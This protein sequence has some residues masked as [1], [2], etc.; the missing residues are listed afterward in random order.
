MKRTSLGIVA[1][2]C[3]F[4]GHTSAQS[5]DI[6]MSYYDTE[7][8]MLSCTKLGALTVSYQN[9]LY[10]TQFLLSRDLRNILAT[11]EDTKNLMRSYA[12][13]NIAG[14]ILQFAGVAVILASGYLLAAAADGNLEQQYNL[15]LY[16][17]LGGVLIGT[18]GVILFGSS[19]QQLS[20]AIN[21]YNRHKIS[22][23]QAM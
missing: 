9:H 14:N 15:S 6:L 18:P 2:L 13:L 5:N 8:F 21:T 1:I 7:L 23:F 4:S 12:R 22:E 17:G 11:Y 16:I 19:L 20:S 10:N 3:I